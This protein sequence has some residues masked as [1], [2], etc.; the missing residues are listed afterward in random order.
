LSPPTGVLTYV[1]QKDL[2]TLPERFEPEGS[3]VAVIAGGCDIWDI[4]TGAFVGTSTHSTCVR[5]SWLAPDNDV[6]SPDRTIFFDPASNEPSSVRYRKTGLSK[7]LVGDC[8]KACKRVTVSRFSH[9]STRLAIARENEQSVGVYDA[10]NGKSLATLTLPKGQVAGAIGWGPDGVTVFA[11]DGDLHHLGDAARPEKGTLLYWPSLDATP[12]ATP[13]HLNSFGG[14][15]RWA[16]YVLDPR[17]RSLFVTHTTQESKSLRGFRARDGAVLSSL[18]WQ[19]IKSLSI[20]NP[21]PGRW[22]PGKFPI[23]Q[24]VD[25]IMDYGGHNSAV[26]TRLLT[27]PGTRKILTIKGTDFSGAYK[28]A[29]DGVS[30]F[31]VKGDRYTSATDPSGRFLGVDKRTIRRVA[32]GI[33]LTYLET[34]GCFRT[35]EGVFDCANASIAPAASVVFRLGDDA[36]NA[37]VVRGTQLAHVLRQVGLASDFFAGKSVGLAAALKARVGLPPKLRLA[38]PFVA[39]KSGAVSIKV[40]AEDAGDGV[41]AIR[42]YVAGKAS[43]APIATKAGETKTVNLAAGTC[44]PVMILACNGVGHACSAPLLIEPCPPKFASISGK[45]P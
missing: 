18:S 11:V 15:G 12:H 39:P 13:I 17:G 9:D 26:A 38:E 20:I 44:G 7:A 16:A 4:E 42:V 29:D 36:V 35:S 21:E 43:G 28:V 40:I 5:G 30:V 22:I 2:P 19:S 14:A 8:A 25:F 3:R 41:S 32:D 6:Q 33:E 34:E 45:N 37:P 24:S 1:A 23:W 10:T 31:A 27:A